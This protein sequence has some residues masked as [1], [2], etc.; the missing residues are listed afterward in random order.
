M[1]ELRDAHADDFEPLAALW[2]HMDRLHARLLPGFFRVPPPPGRSREQVERILRASDEALRVAVVDRA[3]AGLC[4]AQVYDTP[5]LPGLTSCRRT[6]LDSLVVDPACRRRGVGRR[7]VDDAIRWG[8]ARG[9][10]EVVLTVWQ[11]N[12]EAESFYEAL[13]FAR[14]N[15][16]LGHAI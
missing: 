16:V 15:S 2:A 6:H 1:I 10:S 9:A 5:P 3:I 4:H 7:L 8:R 12:E 13:G 11:G 14:I